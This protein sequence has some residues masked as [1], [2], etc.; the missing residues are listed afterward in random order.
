MILPF[1]LTN[2][3][4]AFMNLMNSVFCKYLDQF[5][6]VFLDDILVY[7]KN[8]EEYDRHLRLVLQILREN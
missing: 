2:A 5:V 7:S 4:V 6:L 3:L 1:G 8:V